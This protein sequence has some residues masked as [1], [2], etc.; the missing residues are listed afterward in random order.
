MPPVQPMLARAQDAV[1]D[2]A[3]AW[4]Y[5]PMWDGFRALVFRDG[6]EGRYV[7]VTCTPLCSGSDRGWVG[8]AGCVGVPS[9]V[10]GGSG[11]L[12][13]GGSIRRLWRRH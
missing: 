7:R 9:I 8:W 12:V 11:T 2:Q 5:E 3:G 6:V 10:G 1:P 13:S 4:S